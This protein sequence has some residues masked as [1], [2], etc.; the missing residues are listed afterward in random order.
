MVS[1]KGASK[2]YVNMLNGLLL[3]FSVGVMIY[4]AVLANKLEEF[5]EIIDR[6][7]I[8][9]PLVFAA[10][11]FLVS[12]IGI[13][14]VR[15]H[16]KFLLVIYLLL[17]VVITITLFVSG[18]ILL[19]ISGSLEEASDE[20]VI[21][22]AGS[23][24]ARIV[25]FGLAVYQKCCVEEFGTDIPAPCVEDDENVEEVSESCISD[26]DRFQTFVDNTPETLCTLLKDSEFDD[27][28]LVGDPDVDNGC[29]NGSPERFVDLVLNFLADN[30]RPL[31]L[32]NTIFSVIMLLDL[33]MTCVLLW[34]EK[35]E[36]INSNKKEGENEEEFNEQAGPEMAQGNNE[37]KY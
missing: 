26:V 15:M 20:R 35:D 36:Y 28:P 27:A 24:E 16:N 2:C 12:T 14:A 4:S 18:T 25:D 23:V 5:D 9:T 21:D 33:I 32:V 7:A 30:V 19:S 1:C 11:M 22:A 10:F 29:G 3:L 34:S 37:V 17:A 31:G 13:C 8:I 6:G